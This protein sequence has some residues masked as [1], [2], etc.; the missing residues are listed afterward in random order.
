MKSRPIQIRT[1]TG[2][3]VLPNPRLG[4]NRNALL[5]LPACELESRGTMVLN[6]VARNLPCPEVIEE[7]NRMAREIHDTL[8]QQF[9]GI[10]LNLENLEA[11]NRLDNGQQQNI[12][13]YLDR[14]K[15]LAKCGLEDARRMLLGL[16]PKS[17]EGIQLCDA[18]KAL[19][20]NFSRECGIECSFFLRGRAYKLSETAEDELYRVAQE[21]LCNARKHSGARTVSVLLRYGSAGVLLAI[22]DDGQG[23]VVKK[24]E[25]GAQGF[26]LPTMGERA[27]HLGGKMDIN[28]GQGTG[29]EIRISVPLSGKTSKEKNRKE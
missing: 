21:A 1:K 16:R 28:T 19:A 23:F 17:L 7:R 3:F 13:E 18:L 5:T 24:T 4:K 8:A 12:S 22:R 9:A 26:G 6:R 20:G 2:P 14:A 10:F 29:T 11:A 27:N 15:G 25:A